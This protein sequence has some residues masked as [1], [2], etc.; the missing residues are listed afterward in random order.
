MSD[1]FFFYYQPDTHSFLIIPQLFIIKYLFFLF[2][3]TLLILFLVQECLPIYLRSSCQNVG[4]HQI[5]TFHNCVLW[6]FKELFFY[7][8]GFWN[9]P[10]A[11]KTWLAQLLILSAEPL[12][13]ISQT[14]LQLLS[15][16][17]QLHLL[18]QQLVLLLLPVPATKSRD[19]RRFLLLTGK[20]ILAVGPVWITCL[21]T[22]LWCFSN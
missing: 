12:L 19:G 11:V 1:D 4:G 20:V 7:F 9:Q 17:L 15:L 2:F 8:L 3:F 6:H 14:C 13:L 18:Q 16:Q 5:S 10:F 22:N 21:R